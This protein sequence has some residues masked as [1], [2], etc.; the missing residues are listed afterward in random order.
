MPRRP[1]MINVLVRVI[2]VSRL[3]NSLK[4]SLEVRYT[5]NEIKNSKHYTNPCLK[6][7]TQNLAMQIIV[8]EDPGGPCTRL[9]TRYKT[10]D[11]AY[12]H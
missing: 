4:L 10:L 11:H 8:L 6:I 3:C 1:S 5:S 2:S 12:V 7:N 9:L